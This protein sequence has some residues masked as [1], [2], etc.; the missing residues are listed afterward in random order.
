MMFQNSCS[1]FW[2]NLNKK[3]VILIKHTTIWAYLIIQKTRTR[4]RYVIL[5][6]SSALEHHFNFKKHFELLVA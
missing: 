4:L 1:F 2:V 6:V 5:C 3:K